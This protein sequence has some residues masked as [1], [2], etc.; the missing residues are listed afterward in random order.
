MPQRPIGFDATVRCGTPYVDIR[1]RHRDELDFRAVRA[2]LP[3]PW[4]AGRRAATE[5]RD[6][7][8]VQRSASRHGAQPLIEQAMDGSRSV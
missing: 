1:L 2:P 6:R 7:T 5:L 8:F 3:H 4:A